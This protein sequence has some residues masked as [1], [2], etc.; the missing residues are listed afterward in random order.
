MIFRYKTE[1]KWLWTQE[2]MK[3]QPWAIFKQQE[4]KK[5][6]K[7][8]RR[9][10][11]SQRNL[12]MRLFPTHESTRKSCKS[13]HF[14]LIVLPNSCTNKTNLVF[15]STI[16]RPRTALGQI[17]KGLWDWIHLKY[18][19]Y[20]LYALECLTISAGLYVIKGTTEILLTL[21]V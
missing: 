19:K 11:A 1:I 10:G 15:Q 7:F 3:K 14:C 16:P 18:E 5:I 20:F 2:T 6:S 13:K 9:F 12:L 4:I 8:L 21:N 17:T